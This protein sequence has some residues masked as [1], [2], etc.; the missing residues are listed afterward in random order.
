MVCCMSH[1]DLDPSG[2]T[3]QFRA[4]VQSGQDEPARTR[5]ARLLIPLA[6]I[7][8]AVAVVLWLAL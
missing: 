5:T 4:F 3:E 8:I 1:A 2:N 7:V 6:A